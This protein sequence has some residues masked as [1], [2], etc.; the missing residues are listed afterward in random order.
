MYVTVYVCCRVPVGRQSR[1]RR[2]CICLAARWAVGSGTAIVAVVFAIGESSVEVVV[3]VVWAGR[4]SR[5][6]TCAALAR[7][8]PVLAA[9]QSQSSSGAEEA[10]ASRPPACDWRQISGMHEG[11]L[12]LLPE[13][14]RG[15]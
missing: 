9:V 13:Q 2:I 15:H 5:R 6:G 1:R 14:L 3:V 4:A 10:S 12:D 7:M 11:V 8:T